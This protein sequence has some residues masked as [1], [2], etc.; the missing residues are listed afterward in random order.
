MP[1]QFSI[2]FFSRA[3]F[4][5][6]LVLFSVVIFHYRQHICS[7][8]QQFIALRRYKLKATGFGKYDINKIKTS[9]LDGALVDEKI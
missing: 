4:S 2:G 5:V 3:Y 1:G 7:V 6:Y 9:V 8:T